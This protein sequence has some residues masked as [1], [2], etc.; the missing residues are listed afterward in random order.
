G[1]SSS[2]II[3]APFFKTGVVNIG[4]RQQGRE[5][6]ANVVDANPNKNEIVGA[7]KYVSGEGFQIKLKK[8]KNPY[9]DGY[10]SER[11]V[12]VLREIDLSKKIIQKRM[13]EE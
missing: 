7:I 13:M 2:G 10:A 12:K 4:I 11:I 6:A 5:R 1:N 9:G 8:C 3:E